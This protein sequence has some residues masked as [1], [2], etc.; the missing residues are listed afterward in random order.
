MVTTIRQ[1]DV[2]IFDGVGDGGI[3]INRA[4]EGDANVVFSVEA[5][6]KT[7][8]PGAIALR[9]AAARRFAKAILSAVDVI[10]GKVNEA[11]LHELRH[12]AE[13]H[14]RHVD[15]LAGC[16]LCELEAGAQRDRLT[17]D[18]CGDPLRPDEPL[19]GHADCEN[20]R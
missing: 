20:Q 18:I 6:S 1:Q 17:C 9:P 2:V 15:L 5:D 10:E 3:R 13:L 12:A 19:D 11:E 4:D 14:E 16:P 8:F 7:Y